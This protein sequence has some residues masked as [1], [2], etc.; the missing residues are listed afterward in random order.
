M[1]HPLRNSLH[2][3]PVVPKMY[4]RTNTT[5]NN[6][7]IYICRFV[8]GCCGRYYIENLS[9]N[10]LTNITNQPNYPWSYSFFLDRIICWNTFQFYMPSLLIQ[11]PPVS[12]PFNIYTY[13]QY[14]IQ[15]K[16]YRPCKCTYGIL[17]VYTNIYIC[18]LWEELVY[19]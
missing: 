1:S 12:S 19:E 8:S 14:Q 7:Y 2:P 5:I 6:M 10:Y 16:I 9:F 11:L 3:K 18:M 13:S 4:Y 17:Y 15:D